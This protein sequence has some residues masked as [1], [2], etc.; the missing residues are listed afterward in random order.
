[1]PLPFSINTSIRERDRCIRWDVYKKDISICSKF[2]LAE[3]NKIVSD[4]YSDGEWNEFLSECE[5]YVQ[6]Y[7]LYRCRDNKP[8]AFSFLLQEDDKG[9]VVSLHGGGWYKTVENTLLYYRGLIV[10]IR[11]LINKG[12]KVRTSCFN[13][14][15]V[16]KRFIRSVGFV[17]YMETSTRLLFWINEKRLYNSPI[18]K[19]IYQKL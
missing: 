9:R 1:M 19:R 12:L 5:G 17:Q 6:C 11:N 13:D 8:I 15:M 14:N 7:I 2:V 18:Y 16:A 10:L 3:W 4:I